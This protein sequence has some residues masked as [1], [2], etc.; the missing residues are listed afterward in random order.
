MA[1][2]AQKHDAS[3]YPVYVDE[4]SVFCTYCRARVT[5]PFQ[6]TGRRQGDGALR[7]QCTERGQCMGVFS[8]DIDG[9]V[10]PT[11]AR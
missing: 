1:A 5:G 7:G 9:S 10:P 6:A 2:R 8:F 11:D 4:Q 3:P